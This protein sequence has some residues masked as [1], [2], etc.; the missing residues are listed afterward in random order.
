MLDAADDSDAAAPGQSI[1]W[2]PASRLHGKGD[3]F[4]GIDQPDIERI[5]R[6]VLRRARHHRQVL[7]THLMFVMR[8]GFVGE[9]AALR[10]QLR[11]RPCLLRI[12]MGEAHD[13]RRQALLVAVELADLDFRADLAMANIDARQRDVLLEQ[14]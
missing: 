11:S 12:E 1:C 9:G 14:G 8:P 4:I 5:A 13:A 3:V 2:R 6:D 7:Q 10:P